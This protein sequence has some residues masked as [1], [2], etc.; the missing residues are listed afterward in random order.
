MPLTIDGLT[1]SCVKVPCTFD[2]TQSTISGKRNSAR[3][4]NRELLNKE[5]TT[6]F[7][8]MPPPPSDTTTSGLSVI[9]AEVQLSNRSPYHHSK[10]VIFTGPTYHNS[11]YTG[12]LTWTPRI[13]DIEE[14]HESESMVSVMNFTSSY[15]HNGQNFRAPL[16]TNDTL[17]TPTFGLKVPPKE[18]TIIIQ[19]KGPL[20]E[21]SS[22]S[23]LCKSR[24]N[25]PVTNYTWYKGDEEE[26]EAG[27]SLV[28]NNVKPSSSGDYYCVA[29]NEHGDQ[30]S[31][32]IRLDIQCKLIF[33]YYCEA[34]N[35]HGSGTSERV[36]FDVTFPPEIL[37]SSRCI[38]ISSMIDPGNPPPSLVW[39]L[40]GEPVN[41]SAAIPI[42]EESLGN[43]GMKSI[44]TLYDLDE[45]TLSSLP[46]HQLTGL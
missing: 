10:F 14:K 2:F 34:L 28:L 40:A 42:R 38:K 9:M 30:N 25:P 39:K 21:G 16:S 44:I 3:K 37:S 5:C 13:G 20:L 23:L 24:A 32:L 45:D 35:V 11:I 15:L 27:S 8:N 17:A 36:S 22:V 4:P 12:D 19:P 6:I 43:V 18:T 26:K 29:E 33:I 1:G 7:Y 41:H 31:T 46:Q